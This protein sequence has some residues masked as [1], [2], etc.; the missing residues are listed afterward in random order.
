MKLWPVDKLDEPRTLNPGLGA[1]YCMAVSADGRFL[2]AA[3]MAGGVKLWKWGQWDAPLAFAVDP[4]RPWSAYKGGRNNDSLALSPD[5][6]FLAI[7]TQATKEDA[8][9]Y[10]FSTAD[11]KWVK[12]LPG[13]WCGNPAV[14]YS[15]AMAFSPTG[16]YLASF[17]SDKNATVWDIASGALHAEFPSAQYGAV[18]I[19]PDDAKVAVIRDIR[20]GLEVYD[21]KTQQKVRTL[22]GGVGDGMAVTFSPDGKSLACGFCDGS[23]HVWDTAKWEEKYLEGG[24]L[25]RVRSA[26]FGPDGHTVLSAGDDNTL[27]EWDL[28][29][30]GKGRIRQKIDARL[31]YATFSPDKKKYA[32]SACSVWYDWS[33]TGLV[34]DASNDTQSFAVAPPVGLHSIVFSPDGKL[35]AGS[36]WPPPA[37]TPHVH[38]WDAETGKEVHRFADFGDAQ[39]CTPAFSRDGKL[40]A[41]ASPKQ[42][43]VWEVDS[44]KEVHSWE[45]DLM[46]AAAFSPDARTL[47]TGHTNGTIT[48]WDLVAGKKKKALTGHT[49]GVKSLKFTPDGK[50]LISSGD[51]GTIR[52]WNPDWERAKHVIPLGPANQRLVMDIDPS[53]KY[54]I[55][56]RP[57]SG[58]LHPAAAGRRE[59]GTRPGSEGGGVRGVHRGRGAGERRGGQYRGCW[60]PAEGAVSADVGRSARQQEGDR[61]GACRASKGCTNLTHLGLWGAAVTDVGVFHFQDS[62]GLRDLDLSRTQAT[63]ASLAYFKALRSLTLIESRIGDAGFSHL[64]GCTT[65]VHINLNRSPVSNAGLANLKDCRDLTILYLQ[66][67]PQIS[68]PGLAHFDQCKRLKVVN[69]DLAGV[70]DVGLAH[71]QGCSELES[72][73]L[74]ATKVGDGT[75]AQLRNC[76]NLSNLA[77]SNTLVTDAGLGHLKKCQKLGRMELVN[78]RVSDEGL[79]H[80]QECKALRAIWMRGTQITAAGLADFKKAVPPCWVEWEPPKKK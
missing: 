38:L 30:G 7:R 21:R 70:T 22:A 1:I 25:H 20:Y 2:A 54:L 39:Y 19:S 78:T 80:L 68:D 32:T 16:K 42:I 72:V 56:G 62:K 46:C 59:G 31:N 4:A 52:V 73:A 14:G 63:D 3:G 76:K 43:K 50:R 48:L 36:S 58:D 51:D 18:A 74:C 79:K 5:G 65:L 24:H 6:R 41:V 9:V 10:L 66:Y 8:P 37:K 44:C 75:L 77:I 34:W 35:L 26:A 69:L 71:L 61:R 53:G 60:R 13:K 27:R 17:A 40:L 11:G 67:M 33:R 15:M 29:D 23:V 47:A 55:A 28:K 64:K 49:A 12:T 45:G 57:Q